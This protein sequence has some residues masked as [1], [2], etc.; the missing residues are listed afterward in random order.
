MEPGVVLRD[1]KGNFKA[2]FGIPISSVA[3]AK[4]VEL[5][6]LKEGLKLLETMTIINVVT[7]YMEAITNISDVRSMHLG[8]TARY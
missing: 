4:Q 2:A 6:A 8:L 3:S 7:D 5:C 1:D